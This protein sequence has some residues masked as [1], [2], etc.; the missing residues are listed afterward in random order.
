LSIKILEITMKIAFFFSVH[1]P[2]TQIIIPTFFHIRF[3]TALA[4]V[5]SLLLG[6]CGGKELPPPYQPPSKQKLM[7]LFGK[8]SPEAETLYSRA[9]ILWRG[10]KASSVTGGSTTAEVC[11]DPRQAV[12]LLDKAIELA[13]S[14]AE[15]FVRRGLAKS[16][17]GLRD[18][19]FADI[20]TGIRLSPTP[21]NY[22][23]RGLVSLRGGSPGSARK[24]LDYSLRL[25]PSQHL[26]WNVLGAL[27]LTE[28][29]QEAACEAFDRGCS[30][31]DCSRL[32]AARQEGLCE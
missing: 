22:A 11:S 21:E 31:G 16:E 5:L 12:A 29:D 32:D 28:G 2:R 8:V 20:T 4:L 9:R 24:D 23:L 27:G 6:A 26:A 15:A 25:D 30:A 10:S 3:L 14:Y 7:G 18:E 13:P 19:A 1:T 17:M